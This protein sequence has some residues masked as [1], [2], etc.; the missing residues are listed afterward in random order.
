MS[1][2]NLERWNIESTNVLSNSL[3]QI[4]KFIYSERVAISDTVEAQCYSLKGGSSGT[5]M[6]PSKISNAIDDFLKEISNISLSTR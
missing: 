1:V 5:F 6:M 2:I 3:K 4:F